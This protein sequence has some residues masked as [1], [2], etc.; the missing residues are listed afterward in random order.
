MSEDSILPGRV[1]WRTIGVMLAIALALVAVQIVLDSRGSGRDAPME[2]SRFTYI[3][4]EPLFDFSEPPAPDDSEWVE[5]WRAFSCRRGWSEFERWGAW[6]VGD[7]AEIDFVLPSGGPRTLVLECHPFV[8]LVEA[9]VQ[10]I[11]EV[12]ANDM[13]VG[14]IELLVR[15]PAE[16][17]VEIPD[18]VL[19][20]GVNELELGYAHSMSPREAG[21][22][23]DPRQL[24]VG[25]HRMSLVSDAD[26][27]D[28]W[29]PRISMTDAR[30]EVVVRRSGRMVFPRPAE[31]LETPVRIRYRFQGESRDGR[32]EARVASLSGPR[33]DSGPYTDSVGDADEDPDGVLVV[34]PPPSGNVDAVV[35]D[36][37]IGPEGGP[38]TLQAPLV[39]ALPSDRPVRAASRDTVQTGL[40]QDAKNPPDIVLIILDAARADHFGAYGYQRKTTPFIDRLADDGLVFT[41]AFAVAPYTLCSVPT[42]LTGTSWALHGVVD[43][44][45]RLSDTAVTLAESLGTAGYRTIGYSATPNN[46][47]ALG[48]AQGYDEFHELWG[49]LPPNQAINP[50]QLSKRVVERIEDGLGSSPVHLMLHFVPPHSPYTPAERYDLFTDPSYQGP[51]DGTEKVVS[52]IV[53]NRMETT[54]EDRKHLVDLYDGNLRMA[55]EAVRRVVRALRRSG[56]LANAVLIITSDHGEA[57]F[58]HGRQGHNTTVYDEMMHVP[59]ILSMPDDLARSDVDVDRLA[60][61]EDL[62]PTILGV[63]GLSPDGMV[64]G[65]DLLTAPRDAREGDERRLLFRSAAPRIYALR[66]QR[67]K[68][69]MSQSGR[70]QEL[71]DLEADPGERTN[72]ALTMPLQMSVLSTELGRRVAAAEPVLAAA[73]EGV[74]DEADV[75]A[76]RALGYVE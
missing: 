68:A 33:R 58:E 16:Y 46:S 47:A 70:H 69:V 24:A 57:F 31:R 35:V 62:V 20:A 72:L 13:A 48:D 75:D 6:T 11:V 66:G 52:A 4:A 17:R 45:L 76:L 51:I 34:Q 27:A 53:A 73:E 37:A 38:V 18:G 74:A 9:G 59:L 42:I 55:D 8:G 22:G 39:S 30:D 14:S 61:L 56:R 40:A 64:T 32:I 12:V 5:P 49:E 50:F 65:V 19:R 23:D 21:R 63:L 54:P 25:V 36:V 26:D 15:G 28:V 29:S 10:Q 3:S 2:P 44:G 60:S 1:R 71:F 67:W 41:R 43:R 7:G